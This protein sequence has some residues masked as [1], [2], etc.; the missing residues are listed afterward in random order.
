MRPSWSSVVSPSAFSGPTSASSPTRRH[1]HARKTVSMSSKAIRHSLSRCATTTSW[2]P[3][4][5]ARSRRVMRPR[6]WKLTLDAI[7]SMTS[8]PGVGSEQFSLV[9]EVILLFLGGHST[10]DDFGS[11]CWLSGCSGPLCLKDVFSLGW[12]RELQHKFDIREAVDTFPTGPDAHGANASCF[13]PAAQ[14]GVP[15]FVLLLDLLGCDIWLPVV[16]CVVFREG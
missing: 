3:P 11:S 7:S 1:R 4:L 5:I 15:N 13:V 6:R 10:A 12:D 16:G 2:T 14:R 9:L 8:W